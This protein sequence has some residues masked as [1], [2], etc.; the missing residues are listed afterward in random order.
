MEK[1]AQAL[2]AALGRLER[3]LLLVVTGAGVSA[4]SGLATFR[5]TDPEAIWNQDVTEVGTFR[6]FLRDPVAWWRWYLATFSALFEVAANPAHRALAAL[7]R[8][9]VGRLG[10]FLLVTQN[11]D[12]LHEQA[13]SERLV[14]VHGSGDRVRCTVPGC[15]YAAPAGSLAADPLTLAAFRASPSTA[16]LP[17]CPACG[18]LLRPHALLFDEFYQEHYD[19]GWNEVQRATE[20]M[21]LVLFAGTSFSVGVTEVILRE[22]LGWKIPAFSIDPAP[23]SA[24]A[25]LTVL[26]APAEELLPEVCRRLGRPIPDG[27]P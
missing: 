22:A 21:G 24:P 5:G 10:E 11:I 16:T 3:G 9:Q 8:W 13:G 18:A 20:R 4:A 17:R 19:Y 26:R 25:G 23:V 6:Y 15:R 7:E 2:A 12:T 14:K 1:E 27:T